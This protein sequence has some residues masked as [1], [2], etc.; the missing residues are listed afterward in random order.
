[1]WPF[2][3]RAPAPIVSIHAST[4]TEQLAVLPSVDPSTT[5]QKPR[6]EDEPRQHPYI[7]LTVRSIEA[8]T[9]WGPRDVRM[10]LDA[11]DAG[12][13]AQTGL[14]MEYMTRDDAIY[15]GWSTRSAWVLN[16]RRCIHPSAHRGGKRAARI[17][18]KYQRLIFPQGAQRDI[19]KFLY[20]Y[21][22]AMCSVQWLLVP[23]VDD[24]NGP[25]NWL[26]PQFKPWHP[27]Y[28]RFQ[29]DLS[30]ESGGAGGDQAGGHYVVQTYNRAN[31]DLVGAEAP[32]LGRWAIFSGG[33]SRPWLD[34]L[35]RPLADPWLRRTYTRRDHARFEEKHGLPLTKIFYPS[36]FGMEDKAGQEFKDG[37]RTLGSNGV[38]MCPRDKDNPEGGVDVQFVGPPNAAALQ[39]FVESKKEEDS[40]I[41]ILW[42]GQS[43][44][45]AAGEGGGSHA[46][47]LGMERRIDEKKRDDAI[48]MSDAEIDWF[49]DPDGERKWRLTPADGPIREQVGKFFAWYNFGDP[50][51]APYIYIDATPHAERKLAE[52]L[53]LVRAKTKQAAGL[54]ASELGRFVDVLKAKLGL[55]AGRDYDINHLAKQVGIEL[56]PEPEVDVRDKTT[57]GLLSDVDGEDDL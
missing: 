50:E 54:A 32:G 28:L 49:D 13:F 25:P 19:L 24:P 16:L 6:Q 26:I 47:V 11:H 46:A 3:R 36:Y 27:Y 40:D 1:M 48:W 9:T 2:S 10:A 53:R 39:S 5:P 56:M 33:G 8:S 37:F 17:W 23:N 45:T 18:A 42:L 15:H 14:L 31:I 30:D 51:L 7:G 43:L 20:F 22:F 29:A 44:T 52:D 57:P 4:A 38:A 21:R 34:G 41:Y 12:S 35:V 55:V